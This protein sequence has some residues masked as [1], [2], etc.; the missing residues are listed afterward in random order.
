M[1][2][3]TAYYFWFEKKTYRFKLWL[4]NTYTYPYA[5]HHG[6]KAA[7][8]TILGFKIGYSKPL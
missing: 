1:I 7:E 6:R 3:R 8:M 5:H 4:F 2:I